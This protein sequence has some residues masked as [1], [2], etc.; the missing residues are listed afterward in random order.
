[1]LPYERLRAWQLCD[2]LAHA[3]YDATAEWPRQEMFGIISQARR[4]ALSAP[5]NIAEGC[6]RRGGRELAHFLDIALGSLA[7]LSY[8]LRFARDRKWLSESEWLGLDDLRKRAG[9]LT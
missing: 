8:A 9:G 7:E 2:Q 4:A 3:V 5:M 1:M 6:S